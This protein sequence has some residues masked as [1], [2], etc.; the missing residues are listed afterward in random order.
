MRSSDADIA[1]LEEQMNRYRPLAAEEKESALV[2]D[3]EKVGA[4]EATRIV[5]SRLALD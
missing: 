4:E 5:K 3:T 1:V 2:I